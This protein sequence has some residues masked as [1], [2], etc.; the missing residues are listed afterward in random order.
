MLTVKIVAN[1]I[2]GG[3]NIIETY[4]GKILD[5]VEDYN[6]AVVIAQ[7][8]ALHQLIEHND[9]MEHIADTWETLNLDFQ[10]E[11]ED[12]DWEVKDTVREWSTEYMMQCGPLNS[13]YVQ[14]FPEENL[15]KTVSFHP[16]GGGIKV[17]GIEFNRKEEV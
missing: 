12:W 8:A 17:T 15:I 11:V 14:F 4:N 9:A 13:Q 5:H 10:N 7:R 3:F 1:N 6:I 2:I 16:F